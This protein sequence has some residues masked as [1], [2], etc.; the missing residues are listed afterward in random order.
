MTCSSIY[1]HQRAGYPQT[2]AGDRPTE[3]RVSKTTERQP[4]DRQTNSFIHLNL[5]PQASPLRPVKC[6]KCTESNGRTKHGTR[7]VDLVLGQRNNNARGPVD[8][9]H[10]HSQTNST[11][12]AVPLRR[13]ARTQNTGYL[14]CCAEIS[15]PRRSSFGS[16]RC[17]SRDLVCATMATSCRRIEFQIY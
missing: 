10:K 4:T 12:S 11:R 1:I 17:R 15:G 2:R 6:Q 14:I 7:A 9:D 8:A 16:T 3:G 5:R 13:R